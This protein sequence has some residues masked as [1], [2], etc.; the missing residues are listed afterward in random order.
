ML[1]NPRFVLLAV[2]TA[3]V[4]ATVGV[5]RSVL[6]LLGAERFGLAS[7]TAIASFLIAFGLTKALSD[8]VSGPLAARIGPSRVLVAGWGIGAFVP[9]AIL[10]AGSWGWVVAANGLLGVS[11]GLAWSAALV[12]Q[13]DIAGER[14]KGFAAGVN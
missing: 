14:R 5:E 13:I 12:M 8:L 11:Q 1:R 2:S 9:V 3:F 10:A 6:A 4:G 7:R